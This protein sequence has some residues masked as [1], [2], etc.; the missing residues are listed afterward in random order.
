M[1]IF[2]YVT[3]DLQGEYHKG[4][5][6]TA[7]EVQAANLLRRKHL[8]VISIKS[9]SGSS[10]KF[11]D[12]YLSRVSF[13]DIVVST[14]EL[15]TMVEAGLVLSE[16]LDILEEQQANNKFK[17]ALGEIS[18]DVKGGLDF[19][20]ALEKHPDIYPPLYG[21]LVRAGQASGKLDIILKDL[22]TNLEK[23]REFKSKVK[24]AMIYPALV[25]TMMVAV[26]M[27]M[28]FFVMP[29]LTGLYK[30]SGIELPLPTQIMLGMANFILNFW[31][32]VAFIAV[33]A[34]FF[35]RRFAR[36]PEGRL[37]IDK[38]ILK[39]PV[40]GKVANLVIMTNFTRTLSLLIAAGLS[41]LDSIKIVG[42]ISGNR[43]YKDGLDL[44]YKGVE[45]GLPFSDQILSLKVFPRIVGQMIKIGEETGKLDEVMSRLA[46]HFEAEADNSLK[47]I[48]ALIEPIVLIVLGIGVGLLVVSV[49]LPIYQLTTSIK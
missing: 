29:K 24:G 28:V 8:I 31:W 46:N 43:V 40:V 33:V 13:E 39:M 35:I 19:A 44:A 45:R 6:E 1:S 23:E 14:R 18:R 20:T 3:K 27:V 17:R 38:F 48:T 10:E 34:M 4:E 25:I 11:W 21:K 26:M 41:I 37:A 5:V 36:T 16:A 7:D 47:N 42:D 30:D 9:G 15:A 49:I 22:A 12:K 2:R 32:A